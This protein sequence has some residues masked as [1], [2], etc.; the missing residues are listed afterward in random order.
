MS[1]AQAQAEVVAGALILDTRQ[2]TDRW[3][4]GVIAGSLHTPRTVLEW[5]AD[6]T[7]EFQSPFVEGLDQVLV[8]MCNE[9]YS[10][11]L[12]AFNLQ[13]LGFCNATDMIGGYAAW[14][15]ADLP[16]QSAEPHDLAV[17][18]GRWPPE[19]AAQPILKGQG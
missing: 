1:P 15:E 3:S 14:C 18:D 17:L 13:R 19:P 8:V 5:V 7:S 16:T 10:S 2:D 12:A 6:P 4:N 11:S 9:G